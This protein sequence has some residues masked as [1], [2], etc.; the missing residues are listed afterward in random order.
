MGEPT[1][2]NST[3][4]ALITAALGLIRGRY[5]FSDKG[6]AVGDAIGTRL[7]AGEYD[8][9]PDDRTLAERIT[10]NLYDLTDDRHPHLKVRHPHLHDATE[11]QEIAEWKDEERVTNFEIATVRW[12]DGNV[13]YLDLRGITGAGFGG[14]SYL[15][16]DSE[17]HLNDIYDRLTDGTRQFD[18]GCRMALERLLRTTT[19]PTVRTRAAEAPAE[20]GPDRRAG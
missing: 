6:A 5:V 10:Q 2:P 16:P 20:P 4:R 11:A 14:N 1:Q 8:G 19:S 13:G 18:V 12:L 7:A 9:L 3:R 15:F 17:T